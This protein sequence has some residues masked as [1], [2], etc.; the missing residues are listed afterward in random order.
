[1]YYR[2]KRFSKVLCSVVLM[3]A[4]NI[5]TAQNITYSVV[6]NESASEANFE[7]LGKVGANFLVFKNISWKSILQV[8]DKDMKELSNERIKFLPEKVLNVDFITYPGYFVMV[9]QYKKNTVVYCDAVKM[10]ANGQQ[11]GNIINIDTTRVGMIS[12]ADIY[13]TIYSEDKK[14]ILIYKMHEKNEK[15]HVV[16]KL[17]NPELQLQDSTRSVIPFNE[18]RELYSPFQIA[19]DG[20][21][22][23]TKETKP[24]SRENISELEVI[25][26]KAK[27]NL[28]RSTAIN[29][30]KKFI[31]GVQIKIDN[32]N[33][34]YIINSFYYQEKRTES[35]EGIFSALMSKQTDSVKTRFNRFDDSLRVKFTSTGQY[36]FAFDNLFLKNTFVKRDGGYVLVAE[37]YSTQTMGNNNSWNRWDYLY[38]NPY[39]V[40]NDYYYWNNPYYRYN[41]FNTYNNTRSTRY[42]Y[43]N[44]LI[45]SIDST[46]KPSWSNVILKSQTDDD[47]DG[48]LSYGILNAGA[49]INFLYIEKERNSQIISNQS[50][51]TYGKL[52][53]YPT[54]KSR[55]SGYQFMP[56]LAKQVGAKQMIVPCVYRGNICF[57]R[58]DF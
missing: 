39:S 19:N 18:R 26:N 7:I 30:E 10:D 44:I 16:T 42:Y 37:D 2:M 5:A 46:L 58:V 22:F 38:G 43:D 41:R 32:R 8:F 48:F 55:E 23:F 45:L 21:I 28:F 20:T 53:R 57:A 1:M 56:R 6:H 36:R 25:T 14:N 47:N 3:I 9:Y 12:G 52:Y 31:D 13:S 11:L 29:L 17:Y 15:L 34:N 4:T 35:I 51:S 54:L 24:N 33:N 40:T 27:S 49:E 50:I